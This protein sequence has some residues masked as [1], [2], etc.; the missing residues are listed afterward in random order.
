MP[1]QSEMLANPEVRA[2]L[3]AHMANYETEWLDSTIPALGGRTPR[4]AAA[5]PIAREDL[6]RLLASFPEVGEGGV[7][8]SPARL[9]DALGL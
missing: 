2:M 6:I 1:D 5:D 9:R 4:E 8:M 3:E 7:G